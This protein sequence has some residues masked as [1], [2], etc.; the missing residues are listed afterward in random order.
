[1]ARDLLANLILRLRRL[2]GDAAAIE[3][4]EGRVS[5][6][7][8]R[9]WIDVSSFERNADK[10]LAKGP[11]AGAAA[12]RALAL[13][14]GGFLA[15]EPDLPGTHELRERLNGKFARLIAEW[16]A[17]LERAGEHAAAA[18][19]YVRAVEAEP[20]ME[21]LHQGLVRALAAQGRRPEAAAAYRRL[22]RVLE[23]AAQTPSR[24]TEALGSALI[25]G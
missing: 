6:A 2:L 1:V 17:V 13:Y 25:G 16:G 11:D 3:V 4:H 19:L 7:A 20:A 5:L 23:A 24:E 18:Q 15:D 22:Q 10:A 9:V 21:S 8:G 12:E 14:G